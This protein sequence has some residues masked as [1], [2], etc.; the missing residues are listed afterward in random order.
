MDGDCCIGSERTGP[1]LG[2]GEE[3]DSRGPA[4]GGGGCGACG[5]NLAM[6]SSALE[7]IPSFSTATLSSSSSSS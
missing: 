4:F 1:E 3:P 5:A 7:S 2:R 6:N